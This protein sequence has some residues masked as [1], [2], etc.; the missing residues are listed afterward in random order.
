MIFKRQLSASIT[1]LIA[2]LFLL[3]GL[4][5]SLL[6]A[7][8]FLK[9]KIFN[10]LALLNLEGRLMHFLNYQHSKNNKEAEGSLDRGDRVAVVPEG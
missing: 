5:T 3:P 1:L 4:L 9:L 7:K 10:E 6:I 2:R 8:F